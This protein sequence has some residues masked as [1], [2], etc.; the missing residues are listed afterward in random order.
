ML[1]RVIPS[2]LDPAGNTVIVYTIEE[3]PDGRFIYRHFQES[4]DEWFDEKGGY[5]AQKEV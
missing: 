4:A 3:L 5:I 2:T 1:K